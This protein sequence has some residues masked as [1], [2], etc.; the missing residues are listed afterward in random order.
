MKKILFIFYSFYFLFIFAISK[1]LKG[2]FQYLD[3]HI[4]ENEELYNFHQIPE[5]H[6]KKLKNDEH[7]HSHHVNSYKEIHEENYDERDMGYHSDYN[8]IDERKF[9]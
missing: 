1:K 3:Q 7:K 6:Q 2:N 9:R 4:I 5:Y 8:P